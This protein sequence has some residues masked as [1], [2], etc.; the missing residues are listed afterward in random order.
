MQHSARSVVNA[1]SV[2]Q[3]HFSSSPP[4][5]SPTRVHQGRVAQVVGA[6]QAGVQ[7]GKVTSSDRGHVQASRLV[8]DGVK[9]VGALHELPR[10][11]SPSHHIPPS[12][13]RPQQ[14]R[15]GADHLGIV[16]HLAG[17]REGGGVGRSRK[18]RRA[19][20]RGRPP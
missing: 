2:L 11:I 5:C 18:E 20:G 6:V 9:Q 12:V 13:G 7:A 15:P 10:L 16:Q 3:Q 1:R 19:V 14:Q 17:V 4:G 8:L